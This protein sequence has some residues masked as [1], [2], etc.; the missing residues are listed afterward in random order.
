MD[1]FSRLSEYAREADP[2]PF[3]L[4]LRFLTLQRL[5][6]VHRHYLEAKARDAAR[7]VSIQGAGGP[8][9]SSLALT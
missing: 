9:V 4:W 2:M 6:I 3:F 5:Q 1:A 8:G 7:D